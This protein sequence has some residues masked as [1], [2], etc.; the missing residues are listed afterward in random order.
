MLVPV[1][2]WFTHEVIV[3]GHHIIIKI[4]G[5][6]TVDFVDAD[7][8]WPPGHIALQVFDKPTVAEFRRIEIKELPAAAPAEGFVPLFNGKDRTGWKTHPA[9]PG[10]WRV[11]DGILIGSSDGISHLFTE[12][13]D[14]RDFH[15]RAETRINDGGNGGLYFRASFPL[16]F[17]KAMRRR[18]AAPI[19]IPSRPAACTHPSQNLPRRSESGSSSETCWSRRV[20]GSRTK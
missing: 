11:E 8:T 6:K 13:D 14:W 12:R 7:K 18:S 20:N 2:T 10:N 5:V 9:A 3:Q 19:A 1:D 17:P 4:N 15:L 16:V